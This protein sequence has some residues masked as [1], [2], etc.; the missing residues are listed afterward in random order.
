MEQVV[1]V[2][3]AHLRPAYRDLKHWCEDPTN[4]YVGRGGI[5]FVPTTN[6]GKERYPKHDSPFANPY[7]IRGKDG[8]RT[9]VMKKYEAYIRKRLAAEPALREALQ[10][11][12]GK[13]LGCWCAPEP[14]HADV[15]VRLLHE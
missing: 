8:D 10:G 7:T 4:A 3:V 6:G 9:A 5:V 14:C 2:K 1:N 11:L 15:L 12:R 13:R